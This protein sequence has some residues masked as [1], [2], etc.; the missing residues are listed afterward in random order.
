VIKKE[1]IFLVK[2]K[3]MNKH[4]E[5]RKIV[6]AILQQ[7]ISSSVELYHRKIKYPLKQSRKISEAL[8]ESMVRNRVR[9]GSF[10]MS[11]RVVDITIDYRVEESD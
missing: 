8:G 9:R 5:A 1:A 3:Q 7:V 11:S 6:L 4:Y 2:C 10:G